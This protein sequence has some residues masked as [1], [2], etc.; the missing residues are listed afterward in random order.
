MADDKSGGKH[1]GKLSPGW[2]K[3][4]VVF[5]AA[6]GFMTAVVVLLVGNWLNTSL[7]SSRP[8]AASMPSS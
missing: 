8:R 4:E 7:R 3:A 6:G 1:D 2:L 5:K